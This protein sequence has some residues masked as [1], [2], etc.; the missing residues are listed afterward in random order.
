[1]PCTSCFLK[2]IKSNLWILSVSVNL[3]LFL[4]LC[5]TALN[6]VTNLAHL[7]LLGNISLW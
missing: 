2:L 6:D 5:S 3:N 7:F 4:M 1:M